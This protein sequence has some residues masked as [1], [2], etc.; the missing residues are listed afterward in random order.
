M[1]LRISARARRAGVSTLAAALLATLWAGSSG[2][3]TAEQD[4]VGP[5][6]REGEIIAIEQVDRLKPLSA[7]RSSGRTASSSST[8][9]CGSRSAPRF[10]DYSPRPSTRR[11]RRRTAASRASGRT[12]ASRATWRASR[13]RWRRSTARAIPRPAS[14]L[15]W[16]L[17]LPLGGR[18]PQSRRPLHLLGSRRAAAALL[19]GVGG[20]RLALASP[21]PQYA[22]KGG[23]LFRGEQRKSAFVIGVD[24]PFDAKGIAVLNYRYKSAD[25]PPTSREERRHLG[26]RADAPPRAPH[27]DGAAHRRRLR[28]GLHPRRPERVQRDPAAIRVDAAWA[29]RTS[30]RP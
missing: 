10:A 2:A 7:R 15:A 30:S 14:R 4:A 17:R 28:H 29:S 23:D 20:A 22:D 16:S 11:R 21:E 12:A 6:L 5:A 13:S 8:R 3:E 27:L 26:V 1:K 19:R 24:A 18:R 25:G 9:A